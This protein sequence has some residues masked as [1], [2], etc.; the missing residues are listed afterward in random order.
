MGTSLDRTVGMCALLCIGLYLRGTLPQR[1]DARWT[2]GPCSVVFRTAAE[3]DDGL[4]E[5]WMHLMHSILTQYVFFGFCLLCLNRITSKITLSFHVAMQVSNSHCATCPPPVFP[6]FPHVS[7]C[8][9]DGC[10][11]CGDETG[12][13]FT[14]PSAFPWPCL[15]QKHFVGHT[16]D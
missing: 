7:V 11:R 6:T 2:H 14:C 16:T 15:T 1:A 12:P 9:E 5:T 8:V 10:S 13:H 3:R 4:H